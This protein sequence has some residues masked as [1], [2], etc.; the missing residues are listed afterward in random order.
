[1]LA[2]IRGNIESIPTEIL[3]ECLAYL[4]PCDL[5]NVLSVSRTLRATASHDTLWE[6]HCERIY[7]MGSSDVLGWRPA[8]KHN[9]LSYYL[10][11]RR[12]A[13]VEPYLGWW[14][15]I[16]G[17]AA[18]SIMRI[19]LNDRTLVVSP[20]IPVTTPPSNLIP[21]AFAFGDT[22]DYIIAHNFHEGFP[23]P[24]YIDAQY[25][26]IEQWSAKE[27]VH[28]LREEPS[29]IMHQL[30]RL[31]TFHA[32]NK[33][34]VDA[35]TEP[36]PFKWTFRNSPTLFN[37]IKH[38]G[39]SYD[40]E[41]YAMATSVPTLSF[42]RGLS[43]RPFIAMHSPFEES[44]SSTLIANGI[45]AASYGESHGCEFIHIH[46]RKINERDLSG[47][48]GDEGSLADAVNPFSQDV[49]D[50]FGLP[51]PPNLRMNPEEATSLLLR[52]V[53]IRASCDLE[54][55][56]NKQAAGALVQDFDYLALAIVH[57]GA[58]IAHSRGMSILEY[59]SMFLKK[60]RSMLEKIRTLRLNISDYKYTVYTTWNMCY[61]LLGTHG[62]AQQL[63]WLIAF[64]HC[65]GITRT[66]FQRAT[67]KVRTHKPVLQKNEVEEAASVYL[68]KY[69]LNFG[70]SEEDWVDDQFLDTINELASYSLIEY[71]ERN[72]AY[73]I[74]VLVQDWARSVIPEDV[75]HALERTTSLLSIALDADPENDPKS[76][77]FRSELGL[78]VNKIIS[79]KAPHGGICANHAASF[80][81]VF[82]C[83]G[84]WQEEGNMRLKVRAAREHELGPKHPATLQSMDDLAHNYR[85]RDC[86][87]MAESLY[88]EVLQTR[89]QLHGEE[90]DDTQMS[91]KYLASLYQD[92]R[93]YDEAIP[94]LV[95]IVELRRI[96]KGGNDPETLACTGN[97]ADAYYGSKQLD[98]AKELRQQMMV[99]LSDK[100]PE[101]PMCKRRL[102]DILELEGDW[103]AA[104]KLLVQSIK[105]SDRIFGERHPNA[106]AGQTHLYEFR[107]RKCSVH[108][109]C[110]DSH[111]EAIVSGNEGR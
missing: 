68:Q 2:A 78:H 51:R 93:R 66:M 92:R 65:N 31:Q 34:D 6:T 91:K 49:Q 42:P 98:K 100:D 76:Y 57:A 60:R 43:P 95:K 8:E 111:S 46:I 61:E 48:W 55:Q 41:G 15:S 27:S 80:A 3:I 104:E 89:T 53:N 67:T 102:A 19:W 20:V 106:I 81:S 72:R 97:L 1:M 30:H 23:N 12:L 29:K 39:V 108:A 105:D 22:V 99:L 109:R 86:F 88:K 85:N 54:I 36:P 5:A 40:E 58:Y 35:R 84:Q 94:L 9:G 63:L 4:E 69:L 18:G 13:L 11:W 21:H 107:V 26:S 50:M 33:L 37:A 32:S 110:S 17:V 74:N 10:T 47:Q 83:T 59:R 87:D 24:L 70:N 101:K 75:A 77:Q 16:D 52:V 38:A 56:A 44:D 103:D 28:W 64:L 71:D 45:W 79:E 62:K 96:M 7:N 14:L 82:K 25:I 73:T 90:H